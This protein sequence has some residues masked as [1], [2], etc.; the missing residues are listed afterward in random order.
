MTEPTYRGANGRIDAMAAAWL[1]AH[2]HVFF[3]EGDIRWDGKYYGIVGIQLNADG[4]DA[5]PTLMED[6]Q[7][8]LRGVV[9]LMT[10]L[11]ADSG[12]RVPRA[13][14][15]RSLRRA[16]GEGDLTGI[17]LFNLQACGQV[18]SF[19]DE[20]DVEAKHEAL[21]QAKD[22][23]NGVDP[24]EVIVVEVD[25]RLPKGIPGFYGLVKR[26]VLAMRAYNGIEDEPFTLAF[27]SRRRPEA[28]RFMDDVHTPVKGGVYRPVFVVRW[29]EDGTV[30]K[31]DLTPKPKSKGAGAKGAAKSSGAAR[32]KGSVKTSGKTSGKR[33]AST[34]SRKAAD[35]LDPGL[36]EE[37]IGTLR[38][39]VLVKEIAG[40]GPAIPQSMIKQLERAEA[41]DMSIDVLD[42]ALRMYKYI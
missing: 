19:V 40:S 27:V 25:Q 38:T 14:I 15:H 37:L 26:M 18:F 9:D 7:A 1:L 36:R 3:D 42:L 41:G 8:Y 12:L 31:P 20:S 11:E 32:S 16:I 29:D 33:S 35:T 13:E 4:A 30:E 34:A 23:L 22:R 5:I 21:V 6:P 28:S 24:A 17:T 39:G 2:D 10:A